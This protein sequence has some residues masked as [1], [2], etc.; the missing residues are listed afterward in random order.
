MSLKMSVPTAKTVP[1][2]PCRVL[3]PGCLSE[4]DCWGNY[5]TTAETK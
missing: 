4:H 2:A 3:K 5:L 1:L